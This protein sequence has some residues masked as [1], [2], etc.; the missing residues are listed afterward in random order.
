MSD[1]RFFIIYL[2]KKGI[3]GCSLWKF[4]LF[5]MLLIFT[6][7]I[8]D[9]VLTIYAPICPIKLDKQYSFGR[10]TTSCGTL[11]HWFNSFLVVTLELVVVASL[12]SFCCLCFFFT[13]SKARLILTTSCLI[14][15]PCFLLKI[16]YAPVS[17][18]HLTLPTNR[19]V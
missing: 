14:H 19:E 5:A 2:I 16:L 18:T 17:Y 1:W 11:C 10:W 12:T 13:P 15:S 7:L 6:L 9:F 8:Y 3:R 4:S